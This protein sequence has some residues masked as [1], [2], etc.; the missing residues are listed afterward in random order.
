MIRLIGCSLFSACLAISGC[1]GGGGGGSSRPSTPDNANTVPVADAG[2]LQNV[3]TG[4][5]V[6]LDGSASHDADGDSLTYH[7]QFTAIPVASSATLTSPTS[8]KPRFTADESGLYELALVVN[9]GQS[10]SEVATVSV[11]A[12][13]QNSAPV[14]NAGPDLAIPTGSVVNL[15]GRQSSDADGDPITYQWSFS[16]KPA[17]SL[18]S[19]AN[20][21][22]AQPA[23]TPD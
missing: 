15:D 12:T 21:N 13:K 5:V 9:D 1:G 22:S 4:D 14:A 10:N 16:S 18:V 23:F 17:G 19:L 3:K 11:T 7:W 8:P 6:I 20:A 2:H